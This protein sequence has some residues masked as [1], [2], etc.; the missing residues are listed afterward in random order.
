MPVLNI[1]THGAFV[2][3]I[4]TPCV[5][6]RAWLCCPVFIDY[7]PWRMHLYGTIVCAYGTTILTNCEPSELVGKCIFCTLC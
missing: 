4:Y 1:V 6:T 3:L 2:S 7:Y 5:C